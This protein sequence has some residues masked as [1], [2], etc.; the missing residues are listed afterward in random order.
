[1]LKNTNIRYTK[2]NNKLQM[3]SHTYTVH[4]ANMKTYSTDQR[5]C[6][7]GNI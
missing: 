7:T 3:Q 6:S 4:L 1:M 2:Y 5:H